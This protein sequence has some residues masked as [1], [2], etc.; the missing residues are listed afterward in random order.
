MTDFFVEH[1]IF[2]SQ[3]SNEVA[4]KLLM[5]VSAF[6]ASVKQLM[7]AQ[8]QDFAVFYS[9]DTHVRSP[10]CGSREGFP[11]NSARKYFR[12]DGTV[13]PIIFIENHHLTRD[14][15]P[16]RFVFLAVSMNILASQKLF[17][18]HRKAAQNSFKLVRFDAV[19][20]TGMC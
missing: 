4:D 5:T 10:G 13:A 16:N 3:F 12:Q 19:K 1:D 14:D 15:H 2:I 8:E 18:I 20:K 9:N 17:F 7:K 6:T 11:K